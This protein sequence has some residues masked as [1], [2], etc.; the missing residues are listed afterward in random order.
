MSV[1]VD[2]EGAVG[3]GLPINPVT[4]LFIVVIFTLPLF[5]TVDWV[6]A[7]TAILIELCAIPVLRAPVGVVLRRSVPLFFASALGSI[8]ML[9][10]GQEGGE[11]YF[12]FLTAHVTDNSI[13]LAFGIF[14]R[15][16]AIGL[17]VVLVSYGVDPTDLGRA[18]AQVLHLPARFV[19]GTVAALQMLTALQDDLHA[20]HRARRS[21]GLIDQHG[22]GHRFKNG[23]SLAFGLLVQSLRRA[24][25]LSVAMEARGFAYASCRTWAKHEYFRLRDGVLLAV[26]VALAS[27]PVAVSAWAGTF[28]LFGLVE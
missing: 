14:L 8:P 20:M 3:T 9:L 5:L 23:A 6:S 1:T 15:V 28:R 27:V 17:P 13:Q 21:R 25:T 7:G 18:L 11:T 4:R 10:Y 12:S 16:L 22:F 24:S 2:K 19:L 26:T